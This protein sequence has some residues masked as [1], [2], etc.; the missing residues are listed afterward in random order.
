MEVPEGWEPLPAAGGLIAFGG[1]AEAGFRANA[2]VSATRVAPDTDLA[3]VTSWVHDA[4][5]AALVGFELI[6]EGRAEVDGHPA[7][8]RAVTFVT[9]PE[10]EHRLYQAQVLLLVRDQAKTPVAHLVRFEGTCAAEAARGLTTTFREM[11]RRVKVK[12]PSSP[13]RRSPR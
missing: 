2:V 13:A 7:V 8:M 12:P 9:G 10:G 6:G 4:G 5:A 1:P 11:A 3:A